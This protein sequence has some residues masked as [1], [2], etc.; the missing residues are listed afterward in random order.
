MTQLVQALALGVLIGGVYAL[1]ASGL[2][3]IFGVMH[4]VNVAH[5]ALLVLVAMLTWWMWRHTGIDPIV[6]SVVTTPLMFGLGW[7]LYRG[8]VV[9][10][11]G[12]SASMSV[13]L[14]FGLALTVEGVLNVTAG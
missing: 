6:A 12:A 1:L 10:I 7:A 2:T 4:V 5:G 11:R 8:L 13:L 9:R 3:L 14:T